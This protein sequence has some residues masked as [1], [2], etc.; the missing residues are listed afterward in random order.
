MYGHTSMVMK[1]A[2]SSKIILAKQ[3]QQN[4][5]QTINH[6]LEGFISEIQRWFNTNKSINVTP[7]VKKNEVQNTYH[8]KRYRKI[9]GKI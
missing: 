5:K 6:D 1:I 4:V 2:K 3:I 9:S 8:F 7:Y